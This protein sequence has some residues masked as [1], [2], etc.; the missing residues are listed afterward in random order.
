M[1]PKDTIRGDKRQ[2]RQQKILATHISEKELISK[3]YKELLQW[4]EKAHDPIEK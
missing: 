3:I 4:G 1:Y 2:A